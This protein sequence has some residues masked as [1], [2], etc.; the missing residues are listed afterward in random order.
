MENIYFVSDIHLDS[1]NPVV[2]NKFLNFISDHGPNMRELY[3]LGD[4]FEFWIDDNYDISQNKN[5][6]SKLK[7]LSENGTKIFLTHGNRD[8]LIGKN[9]E[10]ITNVKILN[11]CFMLPLEHR[12]C[13]ALITLILWV[14]SLLIAVT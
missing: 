7:N 2:E 4:L 1:K 6:I 5:I 10:K 11:V 3:I 8:F 13:F 12:C 14:G 9:F